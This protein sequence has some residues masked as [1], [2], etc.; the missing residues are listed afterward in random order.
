MWAYVSYH[1]DLAALSVREY[2]ELLKCQNLLPGR[3]LLRQDIDRNFEAI[4]KQDIASVAQLK[5][6]LSAPQK[7]TA[8][9]AAAGISEEYL[10]LLKR[11]IGSLEQKPVPLASFPDM[12]GAAVA[13]LS[14][15]GIKTSKDY[16][17]SGLSR[18][19]ELF[20]L[21]D[22]V[23]INGVGPVAAKAFYEAG[24]RTAA[25]VAGADAAAMLESVSAVNAD[26][27]YYKGK[28]GVRD[29]QFC[30]DFASLLVRY[31]G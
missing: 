3:R 5:K 16:F 4:E 31:C 1:L 8:L 2:K 20:C 7:L 9:A 10:V 18:T 14:D 11:E 30:I 15:R 6:Q 27:G 26:K 24:Y 13:G 28:L 19:D 17:E 25:Q 12:D 22:L 29:M 23:R 21:C